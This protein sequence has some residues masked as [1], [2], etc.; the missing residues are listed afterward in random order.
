[1]PIP[2]G[3]WSE[4]SLTTIYAL[5]NKLLLKLPYNPNE[6]VF[7]CLSLILLIK[8]KR[9]KTKIKLNKQASIHVYIYIYIYFYTYT[10]R[11]IKG[12]QTAIL[13]NDDALRMRCHRKRHNDTQNQ[14]SEMKDFNG[15]SGDFHSSERQYLTSCTTLWARICNNIQ[16]SWKKFGPNGKCFFLSLYKSTVAL[17]SKLENN[18]VFFFVMLIEIDYHTHKSDILSELNWFQ[19][20]VNQS[21]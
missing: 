2:F 20:C 16:S 4:H 14:M 6:F 17:L 9:N 19:N 11:E 5:R 7:I 3:Q 21:T 10:E 13:I 1:M 18:F 8:E 12:K 15:Q